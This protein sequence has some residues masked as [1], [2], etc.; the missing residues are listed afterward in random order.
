L[1]FFAVRKKIWPSW[2]RFF[3]SSGNVGDAQRALLAIGD[4]EV[5]HISTSYVERHN[6][7]VRMTVRRL[8]SVHDLA[9]ALGVVATGASEKSGVGSSASPDGIEPGPNRGGFFLYAEFSAP[10]EKKIASIYLSALEVHGKMHRR[11]LVSVLL[12]GAIVFL[13]VEIRAQEKLDPAATIWLEMK[14]QLTSP[15]GQEYFEQNLKGTAL[16]LLAGKLIS[17]SPTDRPSVLTLAMFGST[18][19]DVTVRLKGKKG[20]E[21]SLPGSVVA[22]SSIT[23]EGV[24]ISFTA[25]PFMLTVDSLPPSPPRGGKRSK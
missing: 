2:I 23:F 10:G 20:E 13:G 8:W 1:P 22:G 6:L 14:K 3:S 5:K 25:E 9:A 15:N 18:G 11:T 12:S 4:A 24:V 21:A 7:S 17:A 16:P 19:P